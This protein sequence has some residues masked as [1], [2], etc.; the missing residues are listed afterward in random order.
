MPLSIF[1]KLR[2]GEV[3][4]TMMSL[5]LADRS[6]KHP[7]SIIEDVMVKVDKLIFPVDFVVLDMEEDREVPLILR[8]PFLATRRALIDVQEGKLELRVQDERVTFIVFDATKFPSEADSYLK[9]DVI[10]E[11]MTA[12]FGTITTATPLEA[13]L[14]NSKMVE[15][16]EDSNLQL[17]H[18]LFKAQPVVSQPFSD[19]LTL[20]KELQL[21]SKEP[22][23]LELKQ[24][25]IH[26]RYTFL[27]K[28]DTYAV[29]ISASLSSVE[30]EKLLRVLRDHRTA[31]GLQISDL[32]GI[33][34][35]FC[36][37]K[38]FIEDDFKPL[39]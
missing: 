2:V 6:I 23:K 12:S 7:R 17:C 22:P 20:D 35:I 37:H 16:L 13:Y 10:E 28:G 3:K 33:S 21:V 15:K 14:V 9:V 18:E 29:V 25:P 11:V 38:I 26:L 1:K 30:E 8:R 39:V 32:R 19:T 24:L 34:P 4:L 36:M 27:S 31:I 5:Q